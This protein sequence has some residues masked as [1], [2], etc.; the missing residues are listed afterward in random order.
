FNRLS[1]KIP[2]VKDPRM[3]LCILH[4]GAKLRVPPSHSCLLAI[5]P[6]I[7]LL[8]LSRV[9]TTVKDDFNSLDACYTL[10]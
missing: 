5:I 6:Q 1:E 8:L 3:L 10:G 7:R 9:P 2:H 4:A